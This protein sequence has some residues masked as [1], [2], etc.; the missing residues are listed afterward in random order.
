MKPLSGLDATFL[1]AETPRTPMNVIATLV[2]EGALDFAAVVA[3]VREAIPVM[4]ARE[5]M[6]RVDRFIEELFEATIAM[7]GTL[8]GEHGIGIAKDQYMNMEYNKRALEIMQGIK[9]VFDPD[10]ILNPGSFL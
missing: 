6:A 2:V 7:G 1:Y 10:N 4:Q 5:E 9:R 8:T 3:R